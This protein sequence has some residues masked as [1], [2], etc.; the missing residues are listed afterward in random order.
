MAHIAVDIDGT[1][2]AAPQQ[3]QDILSA[4]KACGHRISVLT[5]V[6]S[7]PVTQQDFDEKANFLNQLGMGQSYDDMTVI[8]NKGNLAK[9]KAQWCADNSIDV[10]IDNSRE[11][12]TQA[13][14]IGIPLVLCPWASR[15]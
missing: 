10:L 2:S 8:S 4:L 12:C 13:T 3:F 15:V 11:N 14:S 6:S 1:L 9:A 7:N 5:G